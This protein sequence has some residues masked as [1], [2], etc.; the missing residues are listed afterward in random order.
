MWLYAVCMLR[1]MALICVIADLLFLLS[2]LSL[3]LH[4]FREEPCVSVFSYEM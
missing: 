1:P 3:S 4:A 2:A